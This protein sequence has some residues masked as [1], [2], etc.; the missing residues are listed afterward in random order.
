MNWCE[1]CSGA[2][3]YKQNR[4]ISKKVLRENKG[5]QTVTM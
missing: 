4:D 1:E 3:H 5:V 2:G